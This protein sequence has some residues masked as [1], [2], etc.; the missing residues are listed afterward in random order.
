M[1]KNKKKQLEAK[2]ES[3]KKWQRILRLFKTLSSIGMTCEDCGYCQVYCLKNWE[4]SGKL[5]ADTETCANCPLNTASCCN[6]GNGDAFLSVCGLMTNSETIGIQHAK[7]M[8]DVIR[9]DIKKC[10]KT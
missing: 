1:I 10:T 8:V 4:D 9:A 7:N 3:L 2:K 5:Y 6:G